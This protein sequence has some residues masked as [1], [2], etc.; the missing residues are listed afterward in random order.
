MEKDAVCVMNGGLGGAMEM[1][2]WGRGVLVW[3]RTG[4]VGG[5]MKWYSGMGVWYGYGVSGG[6]V[7][8]VVDV[9]LG[10]AGQKEQEGKDM[11][12]VWRAAVVR[13]CEMGRKMD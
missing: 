9:Q 11:V 7:G 1:L 2:E 8:K 5:A 13:T 12:V 4:L 10:R 3:G 6:G